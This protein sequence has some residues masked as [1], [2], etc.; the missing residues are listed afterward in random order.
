MQLPILLLAWCV[1]PTLAKPGH[2]YLDKQCNV[3]YPGHWPDGIAR[4]YL[5]WVSNEQTDLSGPAFRLFSD[6]DVKLVK[7]LTKYDFFIKSLNEVPMKRFLITINPYIDEYEEQGSDDPG[8]LKSSSEETQHVNYGCSK[9]LIERPDDSHNRGFLHVPFSWESPKKGCMEMSVEILDIYNNMLTADDD[10]FLALTMVSCV[11]NFQPVK[12][13]TE[14]LNLTLT[15][16]FTEELNSTVVGTEE[17]NSTIVDNEEETNGTIISISDED[18]NNVNSTTNATDVQESNDDDDDDDDIVTDA[19]E[20]MANIEP[21]VTKQVDQSE[22]LIDDKPVKPTGHKKH[23]NKAK[24]TAMNR[25][26]NKKRAKKFCCK[27]GIQEHLDN[28]YQDLEGGINRSYC[29]NPPPVEVL[30]KAKSYFKTGQDLCTKVFKACCQEQIIGESNMTK[31]KKKK[32]T[33]ST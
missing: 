18:V 32:K 15:L 4:E 7:P 30:E 5:H 33:K 10:S 13:V 24:K 17:L 27:M 3:D 28:K 16:D 8:K 11:E 26:K 6:V 1:F 31:L 19:D 29:N 25:K 9:Y 20:I 2:D 21:G 14:N 12:K 23:L 22:N